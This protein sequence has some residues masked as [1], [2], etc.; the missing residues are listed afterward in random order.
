MKYDYIIVGA[1]SAGCILANRLSESGQHS[2]LVVEAGPKDGALSLKIP[3]AMLTN[4]KRLQ[5]R[6]DFLNLIW[7]NGLPHQIL[8]DFVQVIF[9]KISISGDKL[10]V[11]DHFSGFGYYFSIF[12]QTNPE[13]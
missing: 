2:V 3:A 10:V 7:S 8:N 13:I 4:L 12:F 9:N 5:L 1:G 6:K 11:F